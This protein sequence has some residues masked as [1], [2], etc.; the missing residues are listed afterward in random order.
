MKY[1]AIQD[2]IKT[3]ESIKSS[4]LSIKAYCEQTGLKASSIYN[5]MQN[6]KKTT[7]SSNECYNQVVELYN[8]CTGRG[9]VKYDK[10]PQYTEV[11]KSEE[12][13]SV[14][15]LDTNSNN[16]VRYER[17]SE[18][19]IQYYSYKIYRKGKN[20]LEG[21]LTREEMAEIY[22]L[23]SYY[24][25]SLTQREVSRHFVDL[26]LVDFKRILSAFDIYKANGPFAPHIIEETDMFELQEMHRRAKEN[27][28]LIK[29]E[30]IEAKTDKKLLEKYATENIRLTKKLESLSNMTF[31][32]ENFPEL[33]KYEPDEVVSTKDLNLYLADMHIGSMVCSGTL[34][35]ENKNYGIDEI[36]RRLDAVLRNLTLFGRLDNL[37]LCLMGDMLD[38][39]GPTN[40]TARLDHSM[41]E[42]MDGFEQADAYLSI[43]TEFVAKIVNLKICNH[44]NL[45]SVRCGNHSGAFE[46]VATKALFN[47]LNAQYPEEFV[48]TKIFDEFFG[49]FEQD[50]H[51]FVITHGKDDRFMKRGLPLNLDD[52]SKMRIYE[53]LDA[54]GIHAPNVHIVKGDLHSSSYNSCHRLDYR[55]VLSL[56]GA[57]DYS[58]FNYSRNS[59][60]VSYD[61]IQGTNILRGEF[62]NM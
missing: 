21:K 4:G 33:P 37:N 46:Y 34:Y 23:Y 40:K 15:Q 5:K 10:V 56:F 60:G 43:M 52:K 17:D 19:K 27:D 51:T 44:I 26:S 54:M 16:E 7:D 53:W 58:A 25:A 48:K 30:A 55:N 8:S 35:S 61:L 31:K 45:Y 39:C 11:A 42:N 1:T 24:G 38:C 18:G 3:L 29:V 13:C 62:Q 2:F 6:F 32:I 36:R 22:R 9:E 20:P 28:F 41:P 59:Y 50:Q 47:A 49:V 14:Q 12:P 57:S